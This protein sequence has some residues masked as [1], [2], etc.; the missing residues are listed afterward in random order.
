[1]GIHAKAAVIIDDKKI[2]KKENI[3]NSFQNNNIKDN[4]TEIQ[5][6]EKQNKR[7]RDLEEVPGDVNFPLDNSIFINNY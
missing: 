5:I 4:E 2:S 7:E 3:S 6:L 1:M